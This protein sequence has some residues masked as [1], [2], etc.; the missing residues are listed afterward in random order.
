MTE[1][2]LHSLSSNFHT[3]RTSIPEAKYPHINI[4]PQYDAIKTLKIDEELTHDENR[5]HK[6]IRAICQSTTFDFIANYE[7]ATSDV[8]EFKKMFKKLGP[9]GLDV[10]GFGCANL[11]NVEVFLLI[12][13]TFRL[14]ASFG[15]EFLIH[16]SLAMRTIFDLG[17]KEQHHKYLTKMSSYEKIGCF[18]LTEPG[19]GSDAAS[20]LTTA[21]RVEGGWLL[22]GEK[23][24][25]GGGLTAD[26]IIVWARNEETKKING[27]LV[28]GKSSG[29][30]ASKIENKIALRIVQN[31]NLRFTNCFVTDENRLQ[32]EDFTGSTAKSLQN[33]RALVVFACSGI[34]LG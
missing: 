7:S 6:K 15:T 31:A 5:Y 10:N 21:T 19:I 16:N 17:T 9:G 11:S 32:A 27:F 22:N 20:L 12:L 24:W 26:I 28:E 25:I 4:D 13:E 18:A 29:I 33:S 3:P 30:T 2:R 34:L 23:R 1:K 8:K 14:D